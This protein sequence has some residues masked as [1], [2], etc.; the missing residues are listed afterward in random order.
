V[1][2]EKPVLDYVSPEPN[3]PSSAARVILDI[4]GVLVYLLLSLVLLGGCFVF[5]RD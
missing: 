1:S 3:P 5:F 2:E 4:M